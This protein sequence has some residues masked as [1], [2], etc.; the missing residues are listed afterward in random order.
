M[1]Y[2]DEGGADFTEG[3]MKEHN[4]VGRAYVHVFV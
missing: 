3:F 1:K 2:G 4:V